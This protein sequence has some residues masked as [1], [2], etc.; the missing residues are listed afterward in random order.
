MAPQSHA[1]RLAFW[2][3]PKGQRRLSGLGR[4]GPVA[5]FS[6]PPRGGILAVA[7]G[8]PN[9]CCP[10]RVAVVCGRR[11][12]AL[13][14]A[15]TCGQCMGRRTRTQWRTGTALGR[16]AHKRG[17]R[18]T[19]GGRRGGIRLMSLAPRRARGRAGLVQTAFLVGGPTRKRARPPSPLAHPRPFLMRTMLERGPG[20]GRVRPNSLAARCISK[21]IARRPALFRP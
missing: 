15:S 1:R 2:W 16:G 20:P 5:E 21:A 13:G 3:E 11:A 4:G 18:D 9:S 12:C 8:A 7:N 6:R 19:E 17:P 14:F 10:L